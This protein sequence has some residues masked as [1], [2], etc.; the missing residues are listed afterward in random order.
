MPAGTAA[1]LIANWA[2]SPAVSNFLN[3]RMA[4]SMPLALKSE[5]MGIEIAIT[6]P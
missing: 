5:I 6:S 3:S 4:L 1:L 2:F